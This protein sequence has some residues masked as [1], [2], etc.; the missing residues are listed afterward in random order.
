MLVSDTLSRSYL[1]DIKPEC[2][3]NTLIQH[4]HFILLNIPISQSRLDQFHLEAQKDQI[5]QTLIC[6]TI[7]V[8][9]GNHQAPKESFP[10]YSQRSEIMYHEGIL[11]KNQ[12][13][14][15][16]TT[17]CSE[18]KSI[19][20]QD[21]FGIENLKKCASQAL[22]WSLINSEIEDMTKNCPTCLTFRN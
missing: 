22:F 17:L 20:H 5:L 16:P 7:N 19:I 14:I 13:I 12:R 15:V 1:N 4:V 11:L 18:M 21:H 8:W 9:P 2:D 6:Y 10:Y 3:E